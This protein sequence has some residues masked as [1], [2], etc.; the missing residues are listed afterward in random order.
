MEM[1]LRSIAELPGHKP[2]YVMGI[3]Y[4]L[5]IIEAVL[6]GADMFDC[7]VPTRLGRNGTAFTS[8]GRVQIRNSEFARQE[9]PIEEGCECYACRNFSRAYIRHLHN[10]GEILGVRLTTIHN[11]HFFAVLMS[12]IRESIE[13]A[14]LEKLK[15][16]YYNL[17]KN[18]REK[19]RGN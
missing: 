15:R 17:Y 19:T 2:R 14:S 18:N 3:G 9:R 16:R 4:P 1:M 11:I 5:D 12:R 7:V 10:V 8:E 6:A 13:S